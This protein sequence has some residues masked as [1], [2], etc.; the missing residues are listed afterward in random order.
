MDAFAFL[1]T[2]STEAEKVISQLMTQGIVVYAGGV[3]IM[4]GGLMTLY[5]LWK[6]Y[7]I[8]AGLVSE[9]LI[10][11]LKGWLI[12]FFILFIAGSSAN[13]LTNVG[14]LMKDT[15]AAMAKDLS[16]ETQVLNIVETKLSLALDQ[17]DKIDTAGEET[18]ADDPYSATFAGDLHRN[19]DEFWHKAAT[20][21]RV[22]GQ[23][24][25]EIWQIF[26]IILKL[27]IIVAGL[28]YLAISL[29]TVILITKVGFMLCLG[30]GPLFLIFSAFKQ[31][32]GWFNSWLNYTIG[33][34]MSYA[35]IM[36]SAKILLTILDVI[37]ADGISWFNVIGS[38][39]ACIVLS[40]II[41]RVGDIAS[42]WFGAGNIADG[43]AAVAAVAAKSMG[44]RVKG[45]AQTVGSNTKNLRDLPNDLRNRFNTKYAYGRN[46]SAQNRAKRIAAARKK[47]S[48]T[49]IDKGK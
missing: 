9:P 1:T 34:G 35:M 30:T 20:P 18:P 13:Y 25:S 42:A 38:F 16:G 49:S 8:M 27:M 3:A 40:V 31:T 19:W 12:K 46:K 39:F 26:I 17:L 33:L 37:W 43:T 6:A 24:L 15:P 41:G 4:A 28:L 2:I 21:I 44:G 7:H 32:R 10:P 14:N 23:G 22:V 5:T 47:N 36:F 29:T 45:M 11:V 48:S